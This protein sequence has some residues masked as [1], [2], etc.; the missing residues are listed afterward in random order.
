MLQEVNLGFN[1]SCESRLVAN[2]IM[3]CSRTEWILKNGDDFT[4]YDFHGILTQSN[5]AGIINE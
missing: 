4:P 5:S 2:T 1:N 3:L